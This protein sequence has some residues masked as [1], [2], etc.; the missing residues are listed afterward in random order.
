MKKASYYTFFAGLLLLWGCRKTEDYKFTTDLAIDSRI[1]RLNAPADTTRIIVYSEG[2]WNV[3]AAEDAPWVSFLQSSGAGKGEFIVKVESNEGNL[4]RAVNLVIKGDR[5]SDTVNLQQRGLTPAINL[6]ETTSMVI[7][8]GGSL[9]TPV[10]TNVP[11]PKMTVTY[12]FEPADQTNWVSPVEIKDGSFF[13]KADTNKTATLRKAVLKLS[14]LDALGTTVSDSIAISQHPGQDY[15]GAVAKDFNYVKTALAAGV[16]SENIYI[17][18]VVIS[19]KGHPN[20]AKNLNTATNKHTL[21]KT[22]NAIAVYVQSPDGTNGLYFKT[23][24]PGDNTFNFNDRV[25]IWLKGATLAKLTGPNRAVISNLEAI[26][27]MQKEAGTTP[28]TPRIKHMSELTDNDLYTYVKLADVELSVPFG[29]FTNVNEGYIARMDC[30]PSSIRDI[31]G[32][33]MYMLTNLDVPYRRTGTEVPKGSGNITGILVSETLDRFGGSLGKYSIRHLK[34]EDIDLATDR[35]NGFSNV[36]VEWSRF[37]NEYA[38]TPTNTQNPMTP[39]IGDGRFFHSKGGVLNFTSTGGIGATSD[40]SATMQD[41]NGKKGAV[42]NGG[43]L[44]RNWWVGTAATGEYW[45][46][47]VSTKNVSTQLSLQLEGNSSPGAPRNY[48]CEWSPNNTTWTSA[49]TY[50]LEDIADWTNTLLTQAPAYKT[51]NINLPLAA[52]GLDKLYI[53]LRAANKVSG[54]STSP[55]AGT[56]NATAYSRLGHISIKYNK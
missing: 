54:T 53:R 17:E 21:D 49:G 4:P 25:K 36:L 38:A 50:T 44:A 30:Y 43:W 35:A 9:K 1:V 24:T 26:H 32:N 20:I 8:S 16:I 29:S 55:T 14:Y 7:A 31:N 37:K 27:V 51:V 22:E 28:L 52:S 19:D 23:K 45:G 3:Q 2:G 42:D 11:L 40:Y 46:I 34:R 41:P 15:A 47:E 5:K 6:T 56:V 33:S 18:G 39:D 48:I 13:F 12:R 10:I